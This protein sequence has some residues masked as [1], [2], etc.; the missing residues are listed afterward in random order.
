M[1]WFD[2]VQ[3]RSRAE[4]HGKLW[5]PD[6]LIVVFFFLTREPA[7]REDRLLDLDDVQ[8]QPTEPRSSKKKYF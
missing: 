3:R 4:S 1:L 7:G 6:L 2:V 8:R 5:K